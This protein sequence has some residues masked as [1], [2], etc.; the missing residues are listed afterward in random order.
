MSYKVYLLHSLKDKK[1]YIGQTENIERRLLR[2]N[3]GFNRSTKMRRPFIL[4][5]YEKYTTRSE[6]RWR[7]YQ[8]KKHPFKKKRFIS[9]LE[10]KY[11]GKIQKNQKDI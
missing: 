9:E 8:L 6:A 4:I 10:N 3:R 11:Y 7:E 2:H 1:Y 5:G